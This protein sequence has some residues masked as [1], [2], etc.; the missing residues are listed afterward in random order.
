M[1]SVP[2]VFPYPPA[3]ERESSPTLSV[4]YYHPE[5]PLSTLLS[6]WSVLRDPSE[7]STVKTMA[8]EIESIYVVFQ[9]GA[10]AHT[11]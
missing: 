5:Y 6:G 9:V 8:T 3:P 10:V 2:R 7:I 4:P 1:K 11:D